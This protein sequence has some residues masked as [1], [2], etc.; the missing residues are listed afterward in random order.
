MPM[1]AL[2]ASHIAQSAAA[3]SA[4]PLMIP[5][6]RSSSGRCGSSVTRGPSP[7]RT[8]RNRGGFAAA[9][10]QARDAA[11]QTVLAQRADQRHQDPGARGADGMTERAGAAVHVDL[12]VGQAVLL[13][14]RHGDYREGLVDLVEID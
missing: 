8:T 13:H 10:A 2:M 1:R 4:G 6:G 11:L 3:I 9:D 12:V 14:G 7:H 5:P